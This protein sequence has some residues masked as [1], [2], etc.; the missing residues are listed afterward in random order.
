MA[1][2]E[3]TTP[4][5][6]A[7]T[8][9]HG[10]VGAVRRLLASALDTLPAQ[11][12]EALDAAGRCFARWGV[13]HTSVPDIARELGVSRATVYRR[14]GTV[15][16]VA[17]SLFVRDLDRALAGAGDPGS[18]AE[19]ADAVVRAAPGHAPAGGTR[20]GEAYLVRV[21]L[22]RLQALVGPVDELAE[23]VARRVS[24]TPGGPATDAA[25]GKEAGALELRDRLLDAA[26]ACFR[27]HGLAN[28]TIDDVVREAHVPRATLYRHAGG[29]TELVTAVLTREVQR[30]LDRLGAFVATCD[31]FASVV[32][33]GVLFAVDMGRSEPFGRPL[34]EELLAGEVPAPYEAAVATVRAEL[35]AQLTRFVAPIVEHA[36]E[37]GEA[38][39]ELTVEDATEWLQRCILSL[40]HSPDP[41]PRT[42][43][44]QRALLE[45][46]LLPAFVPDDRR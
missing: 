19:L 42:R 38:R 22:P 12:D 18:M 16:E 17:W 46:M 4:G 3:A 39:P 32:V 1:Q 35:W 30:F 24:S 45:R 41:V 15:D 2:P 23:A 11:S 33:D 6:A 44:E 34:A 14:F 21:L 9:A 37:T 10:V 27:R 13:E 36:R 20:H 43:E 7:G 29:K 8:G 5:A 26:E 28:T 40:M 25:S 31:D